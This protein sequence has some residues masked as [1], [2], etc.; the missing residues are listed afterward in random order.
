MKKLSVLFILVAI[1]L[2]GCKKEEE[3]HSPYDTDVASITLVQDV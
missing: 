2:S 1:L 3:Y